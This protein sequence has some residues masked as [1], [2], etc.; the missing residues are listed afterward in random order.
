MVKQRCLFRYRPSLILFGG[1]GV[2]DDGEGSVGGVGDGSSL[3]GVSD[4]ESEGSMGAC[5]VVAGFFSGR[6][7]WRFFFVFFLL[8]PVLGSS[9]VVDSSCVVAS[10]ISVSSSVLL[11]SVLLSS[12]LLS[13][14]LLSLVSLSSFSF[15]WGVLSGSSIGVSLSFAISF[16]PFFF[17]LFF[18]DFDLL[19]VVSSLMATVSCF[20]G[21]TSSI[22]ASLLPALSSLP[23]SSALSSLASFLSMD[24]DPVLSLS[25]LVLLSSSA[26]LDTSATFLTTFT[27]LSSVLS[28][29]PLSFVGVLPVAGFMVS[30]FVSFDGVPGIIVSTDSFFSSV[31]STTVF[32]SSMTSFFCPFFLGDTERLRFFFLFLPIAIA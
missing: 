1:G 4:S 7:R 20:V 15:W 31:A 5:V 32:V 2:G 26:P 25:Q 30:P 12:V 13:S 23:L 11:S 3:L 6:A 24:D 29:D 9:F 17:F 18:L 8:L 21:A 19:F 27:A 10:S 14:V 22:V 16:V 28:P